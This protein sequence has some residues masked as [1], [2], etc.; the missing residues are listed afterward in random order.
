MDERKYTRHTYERTNEEL[1]RWAVRGVLW[2]LFIVSASAVGASI[3]LL[4]I[5]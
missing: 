3:A 5:G 2:W 4:V 1:V